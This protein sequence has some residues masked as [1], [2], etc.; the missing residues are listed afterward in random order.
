MLIAGLCIAVGVLLVLLII[1]GWAA[2]KWRGD[3]KEN[4]L[5]A[6]NNFKGWVRANDDLIRERAENARLRKTL[7]R[8]QQFRASV[9]DA[10]DEVFAAEI[11]ER[12]ETK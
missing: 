5:R 9:T 6:A 11:K 7:A 8:Y 12:K 1:A 10:D 2:A 4:S 3:A